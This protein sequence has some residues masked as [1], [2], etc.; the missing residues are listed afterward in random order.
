MG[1]FCSKMAVVDRSPSEITLQNGFG[2]QYAFPY[3]THGKGQGIYKTLPQEEPKKQLS[4]DPYP[5]AAMDGFGIIE[6]GAVE[7]KL[8]RASS[9]KSKTTMEK[10]T[11][12]GKSGTT[13]ASIFLHYNRKEKVFSFDNSF[14]R[15][16][17]LG[18]IMLTGIEL[19]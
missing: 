9:Q 15:A 10:P 4:E 8:S 7:P 14:V 2:G 19:T 5:F 13:K 12:S 16:S 18:Y 3:E 1:V 11:A 6:S 17:T